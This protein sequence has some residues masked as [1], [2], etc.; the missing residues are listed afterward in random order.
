MIRMMGVVILLRSGH[1]WD[2]SMGFVQAHV[3]RVAR[4]Q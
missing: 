2:N 3:S 1:G 4:I